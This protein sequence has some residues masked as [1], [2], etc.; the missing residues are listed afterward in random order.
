MIPQAAIG[1][2]KP[3]DE[4]RS[5]GHDRRTLIR[6]R[7]FRRAGIENLNHTDVPM[8]PCFTVLASGSGGNA[9]LLEADGFG[10]LVDI[11]LGPRQLATRLAACGRSWRNIQAVL[12]THTHSDHWRG[13]SLAALFSRRIPLFC[14]DEHL[15]DLAAGCPEFVYDRLQASGLLRTYSEERPPEFGAAIRCTPLGLRHDGGPTFGFR[16]AGP[17]DLLSGEWSLG[18]LADLGSW[19]DRL[20]SAL[21]D[22]DLLALEFN[23][24]VAMQRSSGRHPMLIARVLG[25]EGHLS[26]EQA[27]ELL[28][29]ALCRSIA[30]RLQRLVQLHLSRQCNRPSLAQSAAQSVLD[31]LGRAVS[32]HSAS[33]HNP[34]PPFEFAASQFATRAG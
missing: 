33:Q 15:A 8:F 18:Y 27:A 31:Q 9:S 7:K 25:D 23:H 20:A 22:V 34:S 3:L 21:S 13:K 32:I 17:G 24:D 30:G 11:G 6:S 10:L 2:D 12:L 16:F 29:E 19:D 26:N 14:H 28:R 5:F 4:R 1:G